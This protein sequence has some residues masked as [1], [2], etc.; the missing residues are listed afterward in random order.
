MSSMQPSELCFVVCL[1]KEGGGGG[2]VMKH[3]Q[4]KLAL[5]KPA[6][7]ATH[8]RFDVHVPPLFGIRLLGSVLIS[9]FA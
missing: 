9:V 4:E 6:V 2:G 7:L 3:R 5:P 1:P 8:A